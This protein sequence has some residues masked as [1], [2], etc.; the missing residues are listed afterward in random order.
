MDNIEKTLDDD[1][2][3]T[4]KEKFNKL[5]TKKDKLLSNILDNIKKIEKNEKIKDQFLDIND[6]KITQYYLKKISKTTNLNTL[7]KIRNLLLWYKEQI[8]RIHEWKRYI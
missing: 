4:I 1:D 2:I 6:N 8:R 3:T 5:T 7:I